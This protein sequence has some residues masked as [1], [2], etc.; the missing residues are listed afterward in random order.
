MQ[1]LAI[2]GMHRARD[3]HAVAAGEALGHQHGFGERRRAVVHRG[4]GHFLAGELAHQR[5]KLENRGERALRE[6]RPDT[7]CRR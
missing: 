5:L 1:N 4:V 7:A 3:E 2:F 6:S